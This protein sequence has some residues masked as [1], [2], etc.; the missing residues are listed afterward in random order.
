M[1][2]I[3]LIWIWL[4]ENWKVPLVVVWSIVI[5][6]L[7]RKNAQAAMDVLEARKESYEKQIV[8]L[9]ENHKRELSERDQNIKEYHKTLEEIEKK[10]SDKN[11][12]ITKAN[13]K[14]V[15]EIVQDSKGNPDVV[16]QKIEELFDFSNFN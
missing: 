14:R 8:Q 16:K 7:S 15:K 1:Y 13:K 10:Y 11:V 3:K 4:K 9:K 12:K 6:A 2:H 5:W